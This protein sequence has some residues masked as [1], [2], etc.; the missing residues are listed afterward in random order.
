MDRAGDD[1]PNQEPS[2]PVRLDGVGMRRQAVIVKITDPFGSRDAVSAVCTVDVA[3]GVPAHRRGI[4]ASRIGHVIAEASTVV[5]RDIPAY[6][7]A[8][9][10]AVAETQYGSARV[11][12]HA[13]VPYVEDLQG[14]SDRTKLSLEHL[15]MIARQTIDREHASTDVGLRVTHLIA[16]PCVQKTYRHAQ[17]VR[18]ADP[19]ADAGDSKALMTHSQRCTT[20]VMAHGVTTPAHIVDMLTAVDGVLFRT[21]NT[22]PRDAE[23]ALVYRAHDTA[24]FIEDALRA[25]VLAIGWV[26]PSP[27]SFTR[28]SGRARSLESIHEY[29]LTASLSLS[30]AEW[31]AARRGV[32]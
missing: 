25:A 8:L 18:G 23:L 17:V 24:Q 32:R 14:T 20:T 9:A 10:R 26:W 27:A 31:L 3:A 28:L 5:Y 6:A 16:C 12:V 29:D 2:Q 22:L 1:V 21:C 19:L 4:H 30:S 7:D 13:R 15:H 11:G